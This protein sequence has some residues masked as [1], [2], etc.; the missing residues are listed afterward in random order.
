MCVVM[1]GSSWDLEFP[2]RSYKTKDQTFAVP[3]DYM[4]WVTAFNGLIAL[5]PF[6]VRGTGADMRTRC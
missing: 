3:D 5:A 4:S 1:S 2:D 6:A